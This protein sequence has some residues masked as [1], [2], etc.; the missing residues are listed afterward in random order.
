ML[1]KVNNPVG[2][3]AASVIL[4][5]ALLMLT[6][7]ASPGV[8]SRKSDPPAVAPSIQVV[9]IASLSQDSDWQ[10][11]PGPDPAPASVV[12]PGVALQTAQT[13]IYGQALTDVARPVAALVYVTNLVSDPKP[14]VDHRLAWVIQLT[15]VLIPHSVPS[16]QTSPTITDS[17]VQWVIDATTG[18]YIE[19]RDFGYPI[20]PK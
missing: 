10:F 18:K 6:G 4:A 8:S 16:S 14:S 20:A 7:C 13:E 9:G 2:R 19:A 3:L 11:E 17:W 1:T 12:S 15:H 5:G